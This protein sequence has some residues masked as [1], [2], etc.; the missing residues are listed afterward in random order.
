M[1][2]GSELSSKRCTRRLSSSA[3]PASSWAVVAICWVAELVRCR[4]LRKP[5]PR[6]R[7]TIHLP[8]RQRRRRSFEPVRP[9][10]QCARQRRRSPARGR[11][12]PRLSV[13]SPRM[14]RGYAQPSQHRPRCAAPR[15]RRPTSR[16]LEPMSAIRAVISTAA[17]CDCS[18]SFRTSSA[19]TAKPRLLACAGSLDG[20]VQR[21]QVCL[22]GDRG[23]GRDDAADAFR[24]LGE[25]LDRGRNLM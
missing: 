13:R 17:D 5:P 21:E 7:P 4:G 14:L 16:V 6:R 23:N 18:A 25:I 1:R 19:T 2:W 15:R 3:A 8:P 10:R 12:S 22:L 9:R 11:S 20:G 24:A